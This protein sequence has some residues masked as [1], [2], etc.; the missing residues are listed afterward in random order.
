MEGQSRYQTRYIASQRPDRMSAAAA[1]RQ[2]ANQ[3]PAAAANL[4][5][6]DFFRQQ[7]D[8]A[9]Y[10]TAED[11]Y[12]ICAT[13]SLEDAVNDGQPLE[14]CWLG[15]VLASSCDLPRILHECRKQSE[16]LQTDVVFSKT[17]KSAVARFKVIKTGNAL[18]QACISCSFSFSTRLRSLYAQSET[19]KD[20]AIDAMPYALHAMN[21][22]GDVSVSNLASHNLFQSAFASVMPFTHF[23]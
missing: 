6:L 22:E 4:L 7:V 11:G 17:G 19:I 10:V 12:I 5:N 18:E 3:K 13:Q 9:C 20:M 21:I 1:G 16:T 8:S 14:S 2:Q 15:D 23:F